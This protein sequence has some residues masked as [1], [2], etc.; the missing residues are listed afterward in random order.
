MKSSVLQEH[1]NGFPVRSIDRFAYGFA[2]LNIVV[3][4]LVVFESKVVNRLYE[5]FSKV[6]SVKWLI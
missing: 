3:S 4:L 6:S 5:I 2:L 1:C